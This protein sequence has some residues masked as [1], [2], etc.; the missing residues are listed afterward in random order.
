[1]RTMTWDTV[2]PSVPKVRQGSWDSHNSLSS[3]NPSSAEGSDASAQGSA[4]EVAWQVSK[5]HLPS[6]SHS[7]SAHMD[8]ESFSK[9][10]PFQ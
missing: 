5:S 7:S 1:M 9:P 10:E 3:L 8:E 2:C 4:G 6:A